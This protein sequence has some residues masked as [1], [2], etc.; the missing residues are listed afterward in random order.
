MLDPARW[1]TAAQ[2]ASTDA[3]EV[4]DLYDS[5]LGYGFSDEQ[6][7]QAVQVSR[8]VCSAEH[9]QSGCKTQGLLVHADNDS[10]QLS[11]IC[12]A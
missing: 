1:K 10:A 8:G 7:Q 5:L 6:V 9:P 12:Q 4:G 2:T 11:A 3:Q